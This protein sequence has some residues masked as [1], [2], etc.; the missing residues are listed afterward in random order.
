M[1]S[2]SIHESKEPTIIRWESF[3]MGCD[4]LEYKQQIV[5]N[6]RE[7]LRHKFNRL[8]QRFL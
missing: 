4:W 5:V 3:G 7:A 6:C 2:S 1:R 8:T